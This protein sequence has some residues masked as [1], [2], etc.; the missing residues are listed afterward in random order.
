MNIT[1]KD[2]SVKTVFMER[3]TA[4]FTSDENLD[5]KIYY[6]RVL[7]FTI[8]VPVELPSREYNKVE[9][10]TVTKKEVRNG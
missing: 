5:G 7:Q 2:G 6:R 8:D 9:R 1:G 3:K 4:F 10:V